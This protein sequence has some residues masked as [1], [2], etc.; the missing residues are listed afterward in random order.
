MNLTLWEGFTVQPSQVAALNP[1]M[2][3]LLIPFVSNVMYPGIEKLGFK[4]TPLRRMTL[5]MLIAALSFVA[6]A[7]IQHRIDAQGPGT[8][9][10]AWQLIPYLVIT[11][12]EVLVSVTGL[13]FA[14][15]Q[16]HQR[17]AGHRARARQRG[18][19]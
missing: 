11:L 18:L 16:A 17:V 8:V 9:T 10:I 15:T 4:A 19:Y 13:E 6:V 1:A 7:L 12:A 14:Y 5:G 3:M 2:V